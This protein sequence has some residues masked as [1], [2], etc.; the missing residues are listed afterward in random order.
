MSFDKN[1]SVSMTSTQSTVDFI[2]D[3]K[4]QDRSWLARLIILTAGELPFPKAKQS[5]VL[6]SREKLLC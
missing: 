5:R 2:S 3:E 1:I 6:K 4:W